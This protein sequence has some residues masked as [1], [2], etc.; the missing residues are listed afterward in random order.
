MAPEGQAWLIRGTGRGKYLAVAVPYEEA[1]VTYDREMLPIKVPDATPGMIKLYT[2]RDEQA[3]LA[4]IRYNRL[5]D[6]FTGVV[7]YSL[8]NHYRTFVKDWGQ[9]ETDELYVGVDR[10]GVHY[11][12]PVQAKGLGQTLGKIQIEQDF[13][14][15]K[16]KA[17]LKN[18]IWR[19]LG[20]QFVDGDT[21]VLYEFAE[22][23]EKI[24]KARERHYR[25]VPPEQISEEDLKIYRSQA[26]NSAQNFLTCVPGRQIT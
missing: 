8:Q 25:L 26:P 21:L 17:Q 4:R 24:W 15:G 2:G 23:D 3:L 22:Q 7:C 11:A 20:T 1:F 19:P 6:V 16:G 10:T 12:F 9:V 14:I 5:V 13:A 18:V